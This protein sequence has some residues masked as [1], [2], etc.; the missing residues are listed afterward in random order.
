MRTTELLSGLAFVALLAAPT[1][2]VTAE[3]EEQPAPEQQEA[4]E[5]HEEKHREMHGE[6]PTQ[7]QRE[8]MERRQAMRQAQQETAGRRQAD[9]SIP[10]QEA[11]SRDIAAQPRM[12]YGEVVQVSS[13]IEQVFGN[14]SFTLGAQ[15]AGAGP[16]VLVV[17]PRQAMGELPEGEQ[18][19]VVG[20]VRP[21][22]VTEFERDYDWFDF[23]TFET[24]F[25]QVGLEAET[26]MRP[27]VIA[28]SITTEDG[29]ELLGATGTVRTD[30]PTDR[31]RTDRP[32]MGR[33]MG[34][35]GDPEEW[36]TNGDDR[37]GLEEWTEPHFQ[38]WDADGDGML[39]RSEWNRVRRARPFADID[40]GEF[41]EWDENGDDRLDQDEFGSWI[42]ENAWDQWDRD[43][44]GFLSFDEVGG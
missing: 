7:A 29:R 28:N 24:W 42:E 22:V 31:P 25:D 36:D 34:P 5:Q 18:V 3:Q 33:R 19:R 13:Q 17:L 43:G 39:D 8:H 6:K 30:V 12:F 4:Q 38:A 21:L 15:R 20:H 23:D 44:D 40:V 32:M 37:I 11:S 1:A 2:P 16:D 9:V 14:R 35:P 41:S 27:V 10:V 26:R